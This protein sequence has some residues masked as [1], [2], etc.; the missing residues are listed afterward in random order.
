[1]TTK[2]NE[3]SID[4]PMASLPP[5]APPIDYVMDNGYG[6]SSAS[7]MS[8]SG[9]GDDVSIAVGDVAETDSSMDPS[10]IAVYAA[11]ITPVSYGDADPIACFDVVFTVG[12][13][14]DGASKTYQV[15]KRIGIDKCKI[16]AQASASSPVSV[17]EDVKPVVKESQQTKPVKSE[18][19]IFR[20]LAG[21]G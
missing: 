21:L 7:V 6:A 3:F 1:M 15:V 2:V 11:T 20:R 10:K 19:E 5:M 17:V 13:N 18:L 8:P 9:V 12:V 16:A 14:C 4:L